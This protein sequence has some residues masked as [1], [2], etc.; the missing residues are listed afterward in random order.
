[1]IIHPCAIGSKMDLNTLQS[2]KDKIDQAILNAH[3]VR[4][5]DYM[6]D[7]SIMVTVMELEDNDYRYEEVP[8][9]Y[10]DYLSK[11]VYEPHWKTFEIRQIVKKN[12][13]DGNYYVRK[14]TVIGSYKAT[15]FIVDDDFVERLNRMRGIS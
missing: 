10:L 9:I 15:P 5:L 12:S 13:I 11:M 3:Y 7:S 14:L 6:K 8:R 1:M 4:A 2:L